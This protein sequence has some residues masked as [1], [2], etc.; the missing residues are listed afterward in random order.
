MKKYFPVCAI[1]LALAIAGCGVIL[2]RSKSNAGDALGDTNFSEISYQPFDPA[3]LDAMIEEAEGLMSDGEN[4]QTLLALFEDI[5][6]QYAQLE[7]SYT[8][9]SIYNALDTTDPVYQ[10]ALTYADEL[11][12][13]ESDA[14]SCLGKAILNSPCGDLARETWQEEEVEYYEE[15]VEMTEEQK[16][17]YSQEQALIVQYRE[18]S[19]REY[20]VTVNGKS[21]TADAL[22]EDSTLSSLDYYAAYSELAKTKNEV[23]GSLYVDLV[24]VRQ[25][26]ADS[27]GYDSYADYCYESVYQRDYTV[28][29]V[30][31]LCTQV[32]QSLVY[33]NLLLWYSYDFSLGGELD[34]AIAAMPVSDQMEQVK[35]YLEQIDPALTDSFTFMEDHGLYHLEYSEHKMN[36]GFTTFLSVYREPF[37]FNQPS[38]NFYDIMSLVHEFGHFHSFCVNAG[39]VGTARCLD[40]AEIHSQGL[41][42]LYTH[43]YTDMLG[44]E[45]GDS[46]IDYTILQKL[47]AVISGCLYDEF[48]RQVYDLEDPTLEEIN[49]I[50]EQLSYQYGLGGFSLGEPGYGWVEVSHNFTNPLYY[51]SYAVSALPA[52]EIWEISLEDFSAACQIYL[53]VLSFGQSETYKE[54]LSQCHLRSP[55]EEGY[56]EELVDTLNDY[57]HL[58]DLAAALA[59]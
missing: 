22:E 33:P 59:S 48:Q 58:D 11:V 47:N 28:E 26:L 6:E 27:Y 53:Q 21:Y 40:L 41:E 43:F 46:A 20:T 37:L 17:L 32:K 38:G 9:A 13:S 57:Y 15:Y 10:E 34:D 1:A 50:F 30:D 44:E 39:T 16:A 24:K 2:F 36:A 12:T 51:I 19:T 49:A 8:M 3:E 31:A 42:C 25:Q 4:A 23:L 18:A 35:S 52:F 14:I 5:L 29:E 7:L 45:Y 54:V 56:I 55:F